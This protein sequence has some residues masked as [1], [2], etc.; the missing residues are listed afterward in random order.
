MT[1]IEQFAL[2]IAIATALIAIAYVT[3]VTPGMLR[4]T[5]IDVPIVGLAPEMEGYTIAALADVH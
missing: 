1:L 4:R 3:L 5:S 2:A